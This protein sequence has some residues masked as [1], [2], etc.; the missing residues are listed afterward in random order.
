MYLSI[1]IYVC[2]ICIYVPAVDA[3]AC[4]EEFIRPI[5][6]SIYIYLSIYLSIYMYIYMYIYRYISTCRRCK[7]LRRRKYPLQTYR[8]RSG[9]NQR[10]SVSTYV[11]CIGKAYYIYPSIY[12]YIYMYICT[13]RR[14]RIPHRRSYPLLIRQNRNGRNRRGSGA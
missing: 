11:Y 13:F 14:C 12:I 5:S 7:I 3:G 9:R 8:S 2:G 6:R 10:G 4:V 1:Y